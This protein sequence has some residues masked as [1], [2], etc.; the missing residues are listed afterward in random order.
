MS[1]GSLITELNQEHRSILELVQGFGKNDFEQSGASGE[2]TAKDMFGH[3]AFWNGEAAKSIS[4]A[5]RNERP[6][7][8]LDG[9]VD[10]INRRE[11]QA[12]QTQTLYKIM[13]EF[14]TSQQAVVNAVDRATDVQFERQVDFKS[15]DGQMAN[16]AWVAQALL[17]HNRKHREA[18]QGWLAKN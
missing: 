13:D 9:N 1:K 11:M 6:A 16:A 14:R 3:I 12:R 5:A 4:L 7:P 8:W 18:L 2:W 17:E 10:E 15:D